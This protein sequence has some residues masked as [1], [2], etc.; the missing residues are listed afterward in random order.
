MERV[1]AAL[2][3]SGGRRRRTRFRGEDSGS[4]T[5]AG[6]GDVPIRGGLRDVS[7]GSDTEGS[8]DGSRH[9]F[10]G[11]LELFDGPLEI[12]LATACAAEV[13]SKQ[14]DV[15]GQVVE[16]RQALQRTSVVSKQTLQH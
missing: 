8:S 7:S 10:I 3:Q 12:A 11:G 9:L 14:L 6:R 4:A 1:A 16:V 15:V 13:M 5:A 2:A